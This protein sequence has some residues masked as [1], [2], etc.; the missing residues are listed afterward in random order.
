MGVLTDT[1]EFLTADEEE[2]HHI[3]PAANIVDAEGKI[4][5]DKDG[6]VICR[7]RSSYPRVATTEVDYMD[8]SPKQT[9]SVATCLI[10]FL[11][12]DDANRAL[13]GSNMQR[14]SVPLVRTQAPFVMTGLE[15][16]A[17][18]DSG[19]VTVARAAGKVTLVGAHYLEVTRPTGEVDAYRL[20]NFLRSNQA[21]SITQKPL[22]Q[23]GQF[24]RKSEPLADGPCTSEGHLALG[25][26]ILVAF[27]PWEGFNY[28]DAIILSERHGARRCL[29]LHPYREIR[30]RS[31]GDQG[32][33]G[34]D[35][36]RYPERRR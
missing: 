23:P 30:N 36:P 11:E 9:V 21:T 12:N 28:E 1:I 19:A 33:S 34:R 10:P 26:N 27:M 35:H 4:V 13:M 14:Q 8:L 24:V 3:I 17:A 2:G 16:R 20:I 15:D 5:P 29:H 25:R 22:V 6:K 7:F 31:S 32:R 18:V